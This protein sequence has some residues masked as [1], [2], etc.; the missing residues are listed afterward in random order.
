[1]VEPVGANPLEWFQSGWQ[2]GQVD[3]GRPPG[4]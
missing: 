2:R 3:S 1:M 4:R